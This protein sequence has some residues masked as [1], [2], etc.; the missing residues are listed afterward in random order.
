MKENGSLSGDALSLVSALLDAFGKTEQRL[1]EI[2]DRLMKLE[3]FSDIISMDIYDIQSLL[4]KKADDI[5][6]AEDH[7][8]DHPHHHEHHDGCDCGCEDED[9]DEGD[10]ENEKSFVRCPFCNTLIFINSDDE[11]LACPFCGEKFMKSDV[12]E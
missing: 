2:E 5:D 6:L 3:D 9:G 8:D 11:E 12:E 4:L 7:E 10:D 1:G